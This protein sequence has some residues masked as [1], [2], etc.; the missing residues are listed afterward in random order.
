MIL[1]DNDYYKIATLITEDNGLV[2]YSND[3]L[4][5]SFEYVLEVDGNIEDDYFNGT[6]SFNCRDVWLEIG[7]ITCTN[8]NGYDLYI[9]FY[10]DKLLKEIKELFNY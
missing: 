4:I 10:H 9:D 3:F 5:L 6:G 8:L 1:S 2:E 7:E